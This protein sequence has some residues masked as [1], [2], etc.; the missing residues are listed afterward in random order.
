M[1]TATAGSRISGKLD[2]SNV[3]SICWVGAN[4]PVMAIWFFRR[5]SA[6]YS[7]AG[8]SMRMVPDDSRL[9]RSLGRNW[10]VWVRCWPL[11]KITVNVGAYPCPCR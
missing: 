11:G 6:E 4:R 2:D 9:C 5:S 8:G 7:P 10:M 1:S 3:P